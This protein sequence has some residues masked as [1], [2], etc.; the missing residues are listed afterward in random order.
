[1]VMG[2]RVRP[3]AD[4]VLSAS[5][6]ARSSA[7][8]AVC[9]WALRLRALSGLWA[10]AARD[11]QAG[12]RRGDQ[13]PQRTGPITPALAACGQ[14]GQ[15]PGAMRVSVQHRLMNLL[16]MVLLTL[17]MSASAFAHRAPSINEEA[18]R[19]FLMAGGTLDDLCGGAAHEGQIGDHCPLCRLD[20]PTG[21]AAPMVW[22]RAADLTLLRVLQPIALPLAPKLAPARHGEARAPPAV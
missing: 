13:T 3:W 11:P 12:C 1:M 14:I 7:E 19:A 9:G 21:L 10:G 16:V 22:P 2:M 4:A 8:G 15:C 6:D 18:L 5:A 20:D 17:A